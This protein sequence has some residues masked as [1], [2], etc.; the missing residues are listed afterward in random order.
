VGAVTQEVR[1]GIGIIS[2]KPNRACG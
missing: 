2:G 1:N